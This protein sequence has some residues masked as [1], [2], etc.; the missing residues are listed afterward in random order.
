LELEKAGSFDLNK[1]PK[2]ILDK[3]IAHN[4]S[5]PEFQKI[6]ISL[7]YNEDMTHNLYTALHYINYFNELPPL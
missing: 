1:L 4:V 2:Q 7:G 3:L 6:A 5:F